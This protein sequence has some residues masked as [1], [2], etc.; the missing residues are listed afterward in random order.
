MF[1][2]QVTSNQ[3]IAQYQIDATKLIGQYCR[4]HPVEA[5]HAPYEGR[6]IMAVLWFLNCDGR[7]S[8]N[9]IRRVAAALSQ[10]VEMF[11][12]MGLIDETPDSE[13]SLL[14]RLKHTRPKS[15]E[16]VKKS[17]KGK[18]VAQQKKVAAKKKKRKKPRKSI[19]MREL[20]SLIR[21]FR[22]KNDDFSHW[23]VGYIILSSRLGWRPGEILALE[24]VGNILRA[25]A[26]KHTNQRGLT[27]TCEIDIGAY[28]ERSQL[29][30][31]VRLISN[32][33]EWISAIPK[34][35]AYY[36]GISKLQNSINSRLATACEKE[37]VKRTCTYTFRHFAISCMKAS[38]FSREEIAVIVNHATDRTA[39]EHY[40]K[41]RQGV[42]RARKMLRFDR[43]RLPL[44]R[45]K[46]RNF[47]KSAVL[48]IKP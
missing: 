33:D 34:W 8:E 48:S 36:G 38:G 40:G 13:K 12:M 5:C 37:E 18:Q 19:P 26:E 14:W 45:Y 42:K 28:C 43:A 3:T 25:S 7:W 23:I 31:K 15:D 22:S 16:K 10:L 17:K 30:K 9:Y 44:V 35:V 21:Y 4:E 24:R 1:M 6:V 41:R 32:L 46:A 39:G 20:R 11:V 2:A 27:D 29:I 47:D